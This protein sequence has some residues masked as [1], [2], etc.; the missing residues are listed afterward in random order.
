MLNHLKH[1]CFVTWIPETIGTVLMLTGVM[2]QA[3]WLEIIARPGFWQ[4][5]TQVY[6]FVALAWFLL[7]FPLA[8]PQL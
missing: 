1:H 2:T 7:L 4:L 5:F 3:E 6:Q 8:G